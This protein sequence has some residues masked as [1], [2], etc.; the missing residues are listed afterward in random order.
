V[1]ERPGADG[2]SRD[3]P[4]HQPQAR[5]PDR[6]VGHLQ[7]TVVVL[8]QAAAAAYDEVGLTRPAEQVAESAPAAFQW[9]DAQA[10]TVPLGEGGQDRNP[11]VGFYAPQPLT[12][13]GDDRKIADVAIGV[14]G[15]DEY[16]PGNDTILVR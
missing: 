11:D 10:E 14:P 13:G 9:N 5:E 16:L 4:G 6:P 3:T 2:E 15:E 1:A 7:Q 12:G 8:E